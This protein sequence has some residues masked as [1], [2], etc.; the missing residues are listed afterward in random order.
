MDDMVGVDWLAT[1]FKYHLVVHPLEVGQMLIKLWCSAPWAHLHLLLLLQLRLLF[2]HLS[3]H[4][5]EHGVRL[6]LLATCRLALRFRR[7][8]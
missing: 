6:P 7:N 8:V 3:A 5:L 1:L 2:G 4:L